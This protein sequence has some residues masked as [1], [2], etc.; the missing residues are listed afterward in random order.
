[1]FKKN[2]FLF[3]FIFIFSFGSFAAMRV[4]AE[5]DSTVSLDEI[6]QLNVNEKVSIIDYRDLEIRFDSV[7]EPG[8]P[9]GISLEAEVTSNGEKKKS[10]ALIIDDEVEIYGV[11]ITLLNYDDE[12]VVLTLV[13]NS[14]YNE[15]QD[16]DDG[17]EEDLIGATKYLSDSHTDSCYKGGYQVD[18]CTGDNCTLKEGYCEG[19]EVK[20]KEYIC[21][22]CNQAV[23]QIKDQTS[24]SGNNVN[25]ERVMN[26]HRF[27]ELRG[28]ILLRVQNNGEAWYLS[29]VNNKGYSLGRPTDAFAVMRGQGVGINNNDL[30][31]IPIGLSNLAG[32]DTDGDGLPD[33][34]E[35]AI[36]T[37]KNNPDTDGDGYNDKAE[38][39]NNY[40][41][42]AAGAGLPI[43]NNFSG[44]Q[45]GKIFLQVERNGEAWY[46]NP[47][48]G[49]RYFLGRPAD[50]FNVMR[51]LSLGISEEDFNDL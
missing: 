18:S 2:V 34:F 8:L 24:N 3:S 13:V 29:P 48:N 19:N 36:G 37:D 50:A 26:S 33:L 38:L 31:K 23:C 17:D 21:D 28:K 43:N 40:D 39:E 11:K 15:C 16:S 44:N 9:F 45:K 20:I 35:D 1:M 25:R 22:S 14:L 30:R 42:G 51:N 41:P 46:I 6:F 27:R 4:G 7:T 32:T 12:S 10:Y 47:N 49:K 5:T